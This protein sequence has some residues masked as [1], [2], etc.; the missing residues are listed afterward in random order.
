MMDSIVEAL[1]ALGP[2]GIVLAISILG[3]IA[4]WR[5]NNELTDQRLED[6]RKHSEAKAQTDQR[7]LEVMMTLQGSINSLTELVKMGRANG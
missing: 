5:R 6:W 4:Q 7:Q 1:V 2:L 3:N